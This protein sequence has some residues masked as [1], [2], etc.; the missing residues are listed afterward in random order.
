[1]FQDVNY[2]FYV[3]RQKKNRWIMLIVISLMVCGI[4]L[5][6]ALRRKKLKFVTPLITVAIWALLFLLGVGVGNNPA[7]MDNLG[8]IGWDAL[9]LTLGA[10]VG[11]L[12]CAWVVYRYLFSG[13]LKK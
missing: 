6:Y 2:I 9:L 3:C 13:Q 11:S 7:I 8:T 1:M 12:V 10:V 5:G 4:V